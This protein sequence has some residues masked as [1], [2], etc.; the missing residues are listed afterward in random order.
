MLAAL[1][2]LEGR[3]VGCLHAH[4][5]EHPNAGRQHSQRASALSNDS[6]QVALDLWV[7]AVA[8]HVLPVTQT[9]FVSFAKR[10]WGTADEPQLI[11]WASAG[12]KHLPICDNMPAPLP[13]GQDR[14]SR[15]GCL[16]LRWAV[17]SSVAGRALQDEHTAAHLTRVVQRLRRSHRRAAPAAQATRAG[18]AEGCTRFEGVNI[19]RSYEWAPIAYAGCRLGAAPVPPPPRGYPRLALRCED[20]C[21]YQQPRGESRGLRGS[22]RGVGT[23]DSK[24]ADLRHLGRKS[25]ASPRAAGP[26]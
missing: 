3:V 14:M 25:G 26:P 18:Q 13:T 21:R 19:I 17:L 4:C 7:H 12:N 24:V 20:A 10:S 16:A 23:K 9:S 5:L 6:L 15:A 22:A 1:P 2:G 8:D 11:P